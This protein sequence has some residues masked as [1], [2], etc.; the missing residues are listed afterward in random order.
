MRIF[1]VIAAAALLI[2]GCSTLEFP[3]VYRLSIE[4]GNI[5]TQE[6]VDQLKPGMSRSQVQFIMGT[7]LLTDTFHEDRWDYLHTKLDGRGQRSQ[8]RLTLFFHNGR[9]D[10]FTGDLLPTGAA[11]L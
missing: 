7:P 3:S 10:H 5:I 2:S 11:Q 8:Q 6:M 9:L 4:Q 1:L